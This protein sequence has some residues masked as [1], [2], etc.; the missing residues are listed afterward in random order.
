[1]KPLPEPGTRIIRWS[2][3]GTAV[4]ALTAIAGTV[5]PDTLGWIAMAI[6]L[7][8]F[9]IGVITMLIAFAYAVG[10][11]RTDVIGVA[12]LFFGSGS[13]PGDVRRHLL[14]SLIVQV[15]VGIATAGIRM[16]TILAFGTL[17]PVF[18]LGLTGLWCAR[19][20]TFRSRH[21]EESDVDTGK[22]GASAPAQPLENPHI[23]RE[24]S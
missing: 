14:G 15:L 6:A 11:S 2:R 8:L 4:F 7:T 13:A 17:V 5:D 9:V 10:R 18:G 19:H 21:C 22:F 24:S 1:M 3:L 12:G 20:G 16:F 23:G